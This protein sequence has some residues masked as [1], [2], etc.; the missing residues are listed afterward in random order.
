VLEN[1]TKARSQMMSA[2]NP[3][4]KMAAEGVLEKALGRLFAVAEAYPDLKANTN[5]L[6]LQ[7]ELT[8]TENKIAFARQAYN[9]S[10]LTYNN[11]IETFPGNVIAGATGRRERTMLAVPEASKALPKVAF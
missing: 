2:Q 11:A 9:D 6:N 7:D 3:A 10:V 4:A 8:H 5:F 1:V